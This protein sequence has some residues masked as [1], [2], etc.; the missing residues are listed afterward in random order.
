M[1]QPIERSAE[2]I[3]L[4]IQ[5]LTGAKLHGMQLHGLKPDE[6]LKSQQRLEQ[7]GGPPV[8]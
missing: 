5:V 1:P 6:W 3:A 8:R 2:R 4:W 7:L